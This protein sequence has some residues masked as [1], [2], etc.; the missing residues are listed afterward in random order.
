MKKE[1]GIEIVTILK[2]DLITLINDVVK[3]ETIAIIDAVNFKKPNKYITRS[4]VSR[5][6]DVNISTLH[7][8]NKS[9]KLKARTLGN[10]VYYTTEDIDNALKLKK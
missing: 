4:E 10:R 3:K 5:M 8:W 1:T 7:N 2:D 6:L 9:G